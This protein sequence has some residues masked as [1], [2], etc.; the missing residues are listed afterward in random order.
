MARPRKP[1][2][3]KKL[4]GTIRPDRMNPHEPKFEDGVQKCSPGLSSGAKRT[5]K[6]VAPELAALGV[7]KK[8]QVHQLVMYCESVAMP[9]SP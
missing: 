3:L 5:W 2:H 1:T 9:P 6:E 7:L 4:A 8:V